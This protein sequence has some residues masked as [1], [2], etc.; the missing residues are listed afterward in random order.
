MHHYFE[1]I[2]NKSGDV[3]VGYFA[4]VID[5][6]TQNTVTLAADNNGT[7]IVTVSGV[8]N[9]A[10]SDE[11]GNLSLYVEPGT[12]NLEIYAPNATSFILRVPNVAM[13][14]GRGPQG[15]EG[16]PGP[17]GEGLEA[18]MAPDGSA[19]VG[20]GSQTLDERLNL[21]VWLTKYIPR[22]VL[23]A[24][25][26]GALVD[27]AGY[28]N[29][30]LLD[31]DFILPAG[32]YNLGSTITVPDGRTIYYDG[33]VRLNWTGTI[34]GGLGFAFRAGNDSSFRARST[35]AEM[36]VV[37]PSASKLF[38]PIGVYGKRNVVIENVYG[39]E[40]QH[41]FVTASDAVTSYAQV[42]TPNMVAAGTNTESQINVSRNIEVIRGGSSYS[43]LQGQT[44]AA[45]YVGYCFGAKVRSPRYRNVPHG[46]QAEGGNANPSEQ[47]A[48]TFERKCQD[49]ELYDLDCDRAGGAWAWAAMAKH[50]RFYDC[51]GFDAHDVGFDF[52]GC[53]DA[54][55]FN[56][57]GRDATFG[58]FANFFLNRGVRFIN[59]QG[60]VSSK[61]MPLYRCFN[62]TLSFD[63]RQVAF[64]GGRFEC[65]DPTGIGMFD[66]EQGPVA[67]FIVKGATFVDVRL[68]ASKNNMSVVTINNNEFRATRRNPTAF[69][70][71]EVGQIHG[72]GPAGQ[73]MARCYNNNFYTEV[74]Q[75][76]GSD[77]YYLY[78][79][80]FNFV[81]FFHVKG[82]TLWMR[83]DNGFGGLLAESG[84]GNAVP[85]FLVEDLM[86]DGDIRFKNTGVAGFY[87]A[88]AC[89]NQTNGPRAFVSA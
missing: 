15:E 11:N 46:F 19:L 70:W 44:F 6:V 71:I 29:T 45:G 20:F 53:D 5:P 16:Q 63:N 85:R 10:K 66:C 24:I 67:D 52:E 12:Y 18:V 32:A 81:T 1:S 48:L 74:A 87:Q 4:R 89:K 30:A 3:L 50:V 65:L 22:S 78:S 82:G 13:N 64:E 39:I 58:V 42:V 17:P 56:C 2:T 49:I 28:I 51:R 41:F 69:N 59:C 76:D 47:G 84:G 31:G 34:P 38:Y 60:T 23:A 40:C 33:K 88:N 21:E 75:P 83:T 14:S 77:C 62:A 86:T 79:D 27:I 35:S 73:P 37:C 54:I 8:E 55:A 7:P 25:R 61:T 80:D 43:A 72:R 36:V 57:I 68:K 26:G 9:M